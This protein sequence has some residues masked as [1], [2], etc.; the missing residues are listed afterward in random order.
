M[1]KSIQEWIKEGEELHAEC[2]REL[3]ELEA[4]LA[5]LEQ[6]RAA[7]MAEVNQI[8]GIIGKPPA[9]EPVR[10]VTAHV[11]DE[12]SVPSNGASSA[13]IARALAGKGLGR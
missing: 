6:K 1:G 12:H 4:Q 10:R 13:T 9:L 3:A 8:A 2:Q 5:E 7:K 11:M